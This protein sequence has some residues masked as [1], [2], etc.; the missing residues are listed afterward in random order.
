VEVAP[1]FEQT[2]FWMA[3]FA[4]VSQLG[5]AP[6]TLCST[7]GEPMGEFGMD[8]GAELVLYWLKFLRVTLVSGQKVRNVTTCPLYFT[9]TLLAVC[10]C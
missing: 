2:D 5:D 7:R 6:S 4:P 9:L 1:Q 3:L 8:V 10:Y